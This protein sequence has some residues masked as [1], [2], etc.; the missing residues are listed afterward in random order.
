MPRRLPPLMKSPCSAE[1]S[2]ARSFLDV[3]CRS[4]A[5]FLPACWRIKD[6]LQEDV[7]R[8][9]LRQFSA[10]QNGNEVIGGKTEAGEEVLL[11]LTP[12]PSSPKAGGSE[13]E[14][15]LSF[16]GE[17]TRKG[18]TGHLHDGLEERG[19]ST[20]IDCK[21]LEKG[22]EI[23]K[24][25]EYVDRSKIIVPIF[26][27]C[28]AESKW[29]LKEVTKSVEC[30]KEIIPV[31]FGVEP[32]DVRN[33]SGPFKSAF[34][35]HQSNKKQDQEEV[36][37]WKEALKK[38]G[39]FSGFN[40][41]KDMNGDE[42]KL[43]RA[44]IERVSTILNKKPFEVAKH[45]VGIE[46]RV[47]DVKK[48]LENGSNINGV[49][50][51]GIHGMGGLGKTTIAKAVY[52]DLG[53]GFNGATCFIS[54]VRENAGQPNGLVNLQKQFIEDILKEKNTFLRDVAQGKNVIKDRASRKRVLLVLDDV[55]NIKQ[56]DA[57]AG[58]RDWFGSGS[59][60]IITTRDEGV[61]LAHNVKQ[62]EIYKP[63]ELNEDQSRALFMFH[64]FDGEQPQGKY[65][66]LSNE[67]VAAAGGLPL[68]VEVIGLLF[69]DKKNVQEWKDTLEKLKKIPPREVQK[70]LKLSYD[71][72]EDLEKKLFLDISC[73][74]IG[75]NRE[76]ATY[77]WEGCGWFP[78]AAIMVL[79]RRSLIKI[80]V[81][82]KMDEKYE[83]FEMHDQIRDMGRAIVDEECS[84]KLQKKSRLWNN[85]DS[86]DL[87]QRKGPETIE[88]EGI[89]ISFYEN[90]CTVSAECF[91]N[92][93][94]LRYLRAEHVNFQGT[95]SCFPTDLKWL[96]LRSCHFDSPPSDFNLE[97]LVILDLDK[98]NMAP[99]WRLSSLEVLNIS[100]CWG[101]SS[102]PERLGE[103]ESLKK[104]DLS[105][106]RIKRLPDSICRLSSLEML[107]LEGTQLHSLPE[108][109]GDME[110]LKN[111][112]L[113]MTCIEVIPD[114][115]GQLTNLVELSLGRSYRLDSLPESICQLK[116]LKSLNLWGCYSICSLPKRLGNMEKL[117]K[118]ILSFTRIKILPDSV[119]QLKL[120]KSLD[121]SRCSSLCSLPKR[122]GDMEKLEELILAKTGIEIIPDS[123][124]QLK[125]LQSLDLSGCFSLC[126]LP[127]RLG[128][129]EKL[130]M[131]ILDKT[132]IEVIPDSI[133]QL[134]LLKSLSLSGCHSL[135]SLPERLGEMEKL[136]ELILDSTKIEAIPDSVGR[137]GNLRLLSLKGCEVIE[138]LPISIRQLSS[139][140]RLEISGTNLKVAEINLP[141]FATINFIE[142][143]VS[144]S[145]LLGLCD[146]THKALEILRLKDAT[147]EDLPDCVGRMKNLKKLQLECEMLKELPN[148]IGSFKRLGELNLK[149]Q[150]LKALPNSIG[151]LKQMSKLELKCMNL[152]SLP[153]SI[154]ELENVDVFIIDSAKLKALPNSIALLGR[155]NKLELHCMSLKGLPDSIGRLKKLIDFKVLSNSLEALPD[156]I[157]SFKKVR[158]LTLKCPNL[159][160]LPDSI[161]ELESLTF[162]E[163]DSYRLKYLPNSVGSLTKL[164]TLRIN[165]INL[166]YLP[167]SM[168]RLQ[169]LER[170]HLH[171]DNFTA[172]PDFIG[173]LE[174]LE[175]FSFNGKKLKYLDAAIFESLGRLSALD[176]T[177]CKGLEYLPQ[178][179]YSLCSLSAWVCTN[180]RKM[181]DISNLKKLR[182]LRLGGCKQLED[183]PGLENISSNLVVLH[184]PGPCD[185]T[186]CCHFSHDFKNKVFKEITFENL[187]TLEISGS[188]VLGSAKGQQQL[189]F[190][191]PRLPFSWL[192]RASLSFR[193]H[194]VLSPICISIIA[195]DVPVPVFE[196]IAEVRHV[197]N[198]GAESIVN[199]G[200]GAHC[201]T[202][203]VTM[204]VSQ[205]ERVCVRLEKSR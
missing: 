2:S 121:L 128:D 177:A 103:L 109:L 64:A 126:A 130:E 29:C 110:S 9:L 95:F 53:E 190:M 155:V 176:L 85:Q 32:S 89:Q 96:Q 108:G 8:M 30:G 19:I 33:Q 80:R 175:T 59:V 50:V 140:Q 159:E 94:N 188:L 124:G 27:K 1:R 43:K 204:D 86:W 61:L 36:R 137:L 63:Q 4:P 104:L 141:P 60:I 90:N 67:V 45:P 136:E 123:V 83:L 194:N 150:N 167:N 105:F 111:I 166:K 100:R 62:D 193:L 119:G 18:F 174:D 189:Q 197:L 71:N 23:N 34:K 14:V 153:D 69:S 73:F 91:E 75:E 135:C 186:G 88:C 147:I 77:M 203:Q 84:R 196:K 42:T 46:T 13:F 172:L 192:R 152:E 191:L 17:D 101:F 151:S 165:C 57:L 201:Y 25:L 116:L 98:T 149:C 183:V 10:N 66:Q 170:L 102:L 48:M 65:V 78:N 5:L 178:L 144:S 114:S 200:E 68:T 182:S 7:L 47:H 31:F 185:F 97:K 133:C 125:L 115:I 82:N 6:F 28:F 92:M 12:S 74:F 40:L 146:Q 143:T 138:A 162:F 117:E 202:I 99:I 161:G 132:R 122:L 169:S 55:D 56:L 164:T 142:F 37:K 51:V 158:T 21:K 118:L 113:Q 76:N 39:N 180:L 160:A 20:F 38:V 106:T 145:E 3:S 15:F 173:R 58:G 181:S 72:L 168:E 49:H 156:S 157:G 120:L 199:P 54:N 79:V 70:R 22:E 179:P 93:P 134:K 154:G 129:M 127:E 198:L 163:V 81:I 16:R 148:W 44:V 184:L 41:I 24:L 35:D 87:L 195:D 112:D 26:S 131:L 107:V 139:L 171:C 52:N 205:L 187:E 11:L